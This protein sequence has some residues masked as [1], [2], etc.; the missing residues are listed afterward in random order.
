MQWTRLA[1][2]PENEPGSLYAHSPDECS[3]EVCCLHNPTVH[4][5]RNA[6]QVWRGDRG[7]VE[8]VCEHGV[9][10]PDPDDRRVRTGEDDG[11]HGCCVGR[12]CAWHDS[13]AT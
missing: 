2:S 7:I 9:G 8:R 6:D 10:H 4:P 11:V 12:C 1:G 3:G 5:L 13:S